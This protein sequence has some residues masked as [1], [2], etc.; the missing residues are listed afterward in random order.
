MSESYILKRIALIF[1]TL[2]VV[3]ILVFGI[4]QILPADAA[5]MMLGENATQEALNAL[6]G[7]MGLNDPIWM[8]YL[9][10]AGAVIQ[11]DFGTSLRTGQPVGP[12]LFSALGTSLT[13]AVLALALMLVLAVPMGIIA[14]VR[15]GKIADVAGPA[16]LQHRF[17]IR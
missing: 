15:R 16:G 1:Y 14:A 17:R 2:F 11:G 7:Q 3:S 10:W 4:T 6:R 13:L 5:V 12:A 9:H 8:Q